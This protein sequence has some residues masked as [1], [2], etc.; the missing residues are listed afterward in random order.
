MVFQEVKG[1][2]FSVEGEKYYFVQCI[3]ADFSMSQGL[4]TQFNKRKDMRNKIIAERGNYN[5]K[6]IDCILI[7][8]TFNLVTKK[9]K[10]NKPTYETLGKSLELMKEICLEQ[11]ITKLAIP[12]LGCGLDKLDWEHVKKKIHKIFRS[13]DIEILAFDNGR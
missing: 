2:L 13:T 3:S 7:E 11:G 10:Y 1:N 12:H 5:K 8:D 6:A 9:F 4:A